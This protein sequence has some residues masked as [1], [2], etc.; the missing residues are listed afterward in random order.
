MSVYQTLYQLVTAATGTDGQLQ[1]QGKTVVKN[2]QTNNIQCLLANPPKVAGTFVRGVI[3]TL[4][5]ENYQSF[6][7]RGS[8][9]STNQARDLYFPTVLNQHIVARP[10]PTAAVMHCHLLPNFPNQNT[11]QLF[12]IPT[13]VV[14][15]N[16]FD[17]LVSY[18]D[19]MEKLPRESASNDIIYDITTRYHDL[20]EDQKRYF[21]VNM[22]PMWYLRFYSAWLEYTETAAKKPLWLRYDELKSNPVKFIGRLAKHYDPNNHY[23]KKKIQNSLDQ[24]TKDKDKL[25]YNKGVSGRGDA[26]FTEKEKQ[27]ITDIMSFNGTSA[28]EKLGVL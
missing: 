1:E 3:I 21:L 27:T 25:R 10:T 2:T 7:S 19:M 5:E 8:Y 4:L 28:L 9:A 26:F 15:R 23:S 14:S 18:F 11:I 12:N 17:T 16:I 24:M 6:L 20:S 13:A 22:A